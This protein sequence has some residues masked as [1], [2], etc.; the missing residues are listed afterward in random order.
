MLRHYPCGN[1][2]AC[3]HSIGNPREQLSNMVA[4]RKLHLI[5]DV[6]DK[7]LL[8]D[9][10]RTPLGRVDGIVLLIEGDT[11]PKV[12]E[13]ESGPATLVRRLS[14]RFARVMH[15]MTLGLGA[16]WTR[17]VRLDWSEVVTVGKSV[18]IK[19]GG[20]YARLLDRERW[21]RDHVVGHIPGSGIKKNSK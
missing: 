5:R 6:L 8:A 9:A 1:D 11:Q 19:G 3:R 14:T 20:Q 16:H 18:T 12:I 7:L 15:V 10:D 13:I 2:R 17:P 21:L 4:A